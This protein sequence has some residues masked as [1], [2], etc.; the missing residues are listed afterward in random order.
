MALVE[1]PITLHVSF[2]GKVH[3]LSLLPSSTLDVLQ[4][5]LE[6]LTSIPPSLQKLI[7]KGKQA[8]TQSPEG[9]TLHDAGLKDGM[10]DEKDHTLVGIQP[11]QHIVTSRSGSVFYV[12]VTTRSEFTAWGGALPCTGGM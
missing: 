2:K 10:K 11:W 4:A 7:Y 3:L 1:E 5:Q 12:D 9:V 8:S 6:E